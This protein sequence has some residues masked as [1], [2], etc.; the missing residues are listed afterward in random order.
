MP[1]SKLNARAVTKM[2]KNSC[3]QINS[4][5]NATN[6]LTINYNGVGDGFSK[7]V[8]FELCLGG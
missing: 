5:T 4:V 2:S 3:H 1:G 7:L 6:I 8:T